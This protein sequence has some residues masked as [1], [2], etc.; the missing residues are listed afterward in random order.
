MVGFDTEPG[1]EFDHPLPTQICRTRVRASLGSRGQDTTLRVNRHPSIRIR[2]PAKS[3]SDDCKT[4]RALLIFN[5][6]VSVL[7]PSLPSRSGF[8][9]DARPHSSRSRA[10]R[11]GTGFPHLLWGRNCENKTRN[12]P[13]PIAWTTFSDSSPSTVYISAHSFCDPQPRSGEDFDLTKMSDLR[14]L[15]RSHRTDWEID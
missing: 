13:F 3:T 12:E 8:P 7:R 14:P 9:W 4:L 6:L 5:D 2:S 11:L 10:G 15:S 1:L